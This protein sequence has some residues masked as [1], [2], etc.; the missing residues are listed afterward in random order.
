M[1]KKGHIILWIV[2][3]SV[4]ALIVILFGAVFL[5]RR[6]NVV[7]VDGSELNYTS[8]EIITSAG[9]EYNSPI[10]MLEKDSAIARVEATFP[11]IKVVQIKTVSVMGI[12]IC[13]RSR[14]P[15]YYALDN[16]NYY[17]LDEELKILEISSNQPE[18]LIRIDEELGIT[19][20]NK[21]CDFVGSELQSSVADGLFTAMYEYVTD[22]T[23]ER[24]DRDGIKELITSIKL[25]DVG[26]YVLNIQTRAGVKIRIARP[27]E[28]L[29]YKVNVC[30]ATYNKLASGETS[31][32][33]TAGTIKFL[34]DSNGNEIIGYSLED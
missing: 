32:T 33:I 11:N 25:E 28:N 6:Q 30:F 34:Y 23:G 9:I 16:N 24:V 8:E 31:G 27:S 2:L 12:E 1:T 18:N 15:M 29:G 7:S 10:F 5:V 21:V 13:V 22:I 3:L 26:Y 19:S 17:V 14:Y 20:S 4:F